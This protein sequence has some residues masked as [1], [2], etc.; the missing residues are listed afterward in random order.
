[1]KYGVNLLDAL[2]TKEYSEF[3]TLVIKCI[4]ATDMALHFGK[5][6]SLQNEINSGKLN[7]KG[8]SKV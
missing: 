2:N 6:T 7:P 8:S 4:I 3:R 1:M 5:Q